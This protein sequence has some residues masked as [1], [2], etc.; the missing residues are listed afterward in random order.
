MWS[1]FWVS[2]ETVRLAR[3]FRRGYNRAMTTHRNGGTP[4]TGPGRYWALFAALAAVT[5]GEWLLFAARG[6]L[7]L[8]PDGLVP[9][10][11]ATSVVKFGVVVAWFMR[12]RAGLAWPKKA[13]LVA[14]VVGGGLVLAPRLLMKS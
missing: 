10:F 12:S 14:L 8:S 9:V 7:G 2:T 13:A 1:S 4:V 11:L 5:V 3:G 6:S